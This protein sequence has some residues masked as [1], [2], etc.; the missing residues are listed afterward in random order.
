MFAV[1]SARRVL[2]LG[3]ALVTTGVLSVALA[4]TPAMAS[5]ITLQATI[6]CSNYNSFG[7]TRDWYPIG[8]SVSASPYGTGGAGTVVAV[9]AT[10]AW[11]IT[12]TLPSGTTAVGASGRCSEGHQY[13]FL[14]STASI[15]IPAGV[16]TVTATWNCS[17]APVYPGPWM[18]N[19][20]VQ[21]V[22]YS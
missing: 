1:N 13:D 20:S 8:P 22:S 3:A 7:D 4:P 14:G 2:A 5:T 21:S 17:T 6:D 16:T 12:H 18:T 19:C 11:Q 9:P 10:H 15:S